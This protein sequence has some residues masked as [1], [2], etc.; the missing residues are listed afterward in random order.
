MYQNYSYSPKL[1]SA[2]FGRSVSFFFCEEERIFPLCG[3][4]GVRL[5]FGFLFKNTR[6]GLEFRFYFFT[7]LVS[8]TLV[9]SILGACLTVV[10][11]SEISF[12]GGSFSR[13]TFFSFGREREGRMLTMFFY[14]LRFCFSLPLA[15]L[16]ALI[17]SFFGFIE[18]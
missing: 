10:S 7:P 6:S 2:L 18:L 11:L 5:S 3:S 9:V 16:F 13:I 8:G 12:I 14:Y 17:A 1:P 4:Q 15:I